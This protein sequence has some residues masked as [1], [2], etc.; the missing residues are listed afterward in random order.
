MRGKAMTSN[1]LQAGTRDPLIS[2]LSRRSVSPKRLVHPAP[3]RE[4]LNSI[5]GSALRAPDHGALLPWRVIEFPAET[6]YRLA[7]LFSAEKLRRVPVAS[8][9]D[10]QRARE[11][12]THAPTV[13]A[14]VVRAQRHPLVPVVEQWLSAG[15]A[16]G[17]LL[18]AAHLLGFGAIILSGERC[19]DESLRAA[20]G[21]AA[22]EVLAGFISMGTVATAPPAAV[23]PARERVWSAWAPHP[24][25][26]DRKA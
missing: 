15:A 8:A 22:D 4:A 5:V 19:Q 13:L 1:H 3:D 26:S 12:A 24:V 10:L 14:F 2:L 11:H 18:S 9:E 6:R 16:L 20:L 17:N 23:R 21:V 7:D 25:H